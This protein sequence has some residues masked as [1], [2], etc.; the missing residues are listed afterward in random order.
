MYGNLRV[1]CDE[2]G[3]IEITLNGETKSFQGVRR[4]FTYPIDS[5]GCWSVSNCLNV[6]FPTSKRVRPGTVQIN[7]NGKVY[8][9][10]DRPRSSSTELV[11]IGFSV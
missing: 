7:D 10:A 9:I 5:K 11:L 4:E 6:R 3:G 8:I 2:K 1:D